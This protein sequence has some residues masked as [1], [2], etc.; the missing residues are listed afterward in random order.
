LTFDPER[1]GKAKAKDVE[2]QRDQTSTDPQRSAA[3]E[4][5]SLRDTHLLVQTATQTAESIV[6]NEK[7]TE[8]IPTDD[9]LARQLKQLNV[10]GKPIRGVGDSSKG[11]RSLYSTPIKQILKMKAVGQL[12][13]EH[14]FANLPPE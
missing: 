10:T 4:H 9:L 7:L 8:E 5:D 13:Y 11:I 14:N 12:A 6:S 3:R 1:D 2:V